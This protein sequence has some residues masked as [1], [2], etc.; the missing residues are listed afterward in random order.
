MNK[1]KDF[2]KACDAITLNLDGK[3]IKRKDAQMTAETIMDNL[4]VEY[5]KKRYETYT[6]YYVVVDDQTGGTLD[7]Y[8]TYTPK[9]IKVTHQ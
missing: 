3:R 7:I 1:L 2:K 8:L 6:A 9:G 4:Q 5:S